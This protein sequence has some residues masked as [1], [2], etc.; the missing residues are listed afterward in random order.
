MTLAMTG[1]VWITDGSSTVV[2]QQIEDADIDDEPDSADEP[3][4]HEL[5]DQ[6]SH[7]SLGSDGR[8]LT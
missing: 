3:E 6:A 1:P 7:D 5:G 4:P 8:R 2:A